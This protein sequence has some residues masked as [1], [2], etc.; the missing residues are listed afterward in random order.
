MEKE[1]SNKDI[2]LFALYKLGGISKKVHVEEI[3]WESYQLAKERFSWRLP[4]F[5]KQGFPDKTLINFTL[6]DVKKKKNGRL[7]AGRAGGNVSGESEGWRF[8]REGVIWIK[9]NE[10]RI[11]AGLKQDEKAPDMPRRDA[12]RYMFTD[13]LVCAPDA[14]K[15]IIKQKFEH[16]YSNA[17]LIN[18][19]EILTFLKACKEK[20]SD[21]IV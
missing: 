9:E 2:V 11:L 12:S 3:T 1:L 10:K 7:V 8:T 17:E 21:L 16:L 19:T 4:Q 6:A 15:D 20:F 18:D 14:S 13:M 5:R